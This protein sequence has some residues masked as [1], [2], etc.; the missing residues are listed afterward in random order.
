MEI[1]KNISVSQVRRV[2]GGVSNTHRLTGE[3]YETIY[4]VTGAMNI[5]TPELMDELSKDEVDKLIGDG[6]QVVIFNEGRVEMS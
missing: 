1:L 5:T 3:D 2:K 4:V 6:V